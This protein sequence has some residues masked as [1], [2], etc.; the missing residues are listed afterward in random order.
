[1]PGKTCGAKTTKCAKCGQHR[2]EHQPGRKAEACTFRAVPCKKKPMA[3]G[4][5]KFH[6]GGSLAGPAHPNYRTGRHSTY[7]P[8]KLGERYAEGLSNPNLTELR[9]EVALVDVRIGQLLELAGAHGNK[10]LWVEALKAF[11]TFKAAAAKGPEAVAPARVALTGLERILNEGKEE[12]AT[13]EELRETIDL[14][15]RLAESETKR[16][17]DLHQMISVSQAMQ[18]MDTLITVVKT[19]VKDRPALAAISAQFVRLVGSGS[20]EPPEA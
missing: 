5:C 20:G 8:K 17:K 12:S 6:G 16:M 19:H 13:W 15:R 7:L 3:N 18:M 11:D 10:R 2:R 1:M 9:S 14:R 4:R